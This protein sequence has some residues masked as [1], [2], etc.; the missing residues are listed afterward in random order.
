MYWFKGR[1]KIFK[2]AHDVA[3]VSTLLTAVE[4][5]AGYAKRVENKPE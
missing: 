1:V 5:G 4:R 3:D 2:I